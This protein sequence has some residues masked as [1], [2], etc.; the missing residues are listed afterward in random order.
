MS[1]SLNYEAP[2]DRAWR[3]AY[4]RKRVPDSALGKA[5]FFLFCTSLLICL[6]AGTIGAIAG[7]AGEGVGVGWLIGSIMNGLVGVPLAA[8]GL[9]D[10]P[11]IRRRYAV[12][13]MCL[14]VGWFV[15]MFAGIW[16]ISRAW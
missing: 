9:A 12:W 1:P 3:A 2:R 5:S 4:A 13:A 16:M 7:H 10:G 8:G 6:A 14:H 11:D 15:I